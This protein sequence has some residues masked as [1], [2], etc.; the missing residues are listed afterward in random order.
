MKRLC[1]TLALVLGGP[2]LGGCG[3]A[4]TSPAG[5][6]AGKECSAL[7]TVIN[8]GIDK[9]IKITSA[10][11]D[12]GAAAT[13]LRAVA[14]EMDGVAQQ[15]AAVELTLAELQQLSG[16]YQAMVEEVAAGSR[17]LANAVDNV[18]SE[19]MKQ[20]REKIAKAVAREDALVERVNRFCQ[21][22]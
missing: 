7:V 10:T 11:P 3:G 2:L 13:E 14:R 16:D 9:L 17:E 6:A 19:K 20:A 21:T 18:D 5:P 1:T 12:G 15:A 22:P 8:D 4:T